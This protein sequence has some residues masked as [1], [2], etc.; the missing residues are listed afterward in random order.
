MEKFVSQ[1][2]GV[3]AKLHGASR[4]RDART[5]NGVRR[6]RWSKER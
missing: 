2:E 3:V 1:L 4:P 6:R 5:E